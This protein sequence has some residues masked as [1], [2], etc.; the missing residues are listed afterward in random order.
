MQSYA[1]TEANLAAPAPPPVR[2]GDKKRWILNAFE[3]ST[4]GH[5]FPGL[6]KHPKD[7]SSHYHDIEYWTE[8]S[9]T[10]ERGKFNGILCV[11][12]FF[13]VFACSPSLPSCLDRLALNLLPI[14]TASP[15]PLEPT[16]SSR[17]LPPAFFLPHTFLFL[18]LPPPRRLRWKSRRRRSNWC[19]VG[20]R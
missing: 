10:L 7:R 6:W 18:L 8:L 5:Q 14:L 3:M 17:S 16:V 12:S 11:C 13:F 2:G 4:S 20:S 1:T 15:T 9:K 19:S